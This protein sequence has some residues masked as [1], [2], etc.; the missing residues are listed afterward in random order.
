MEVDLLNLEPQHIS[1]NLKGKFIL[2][3]GEPGCGKTSLGAELPKA[4][5]LG[6]EQGTNA[7]DN[8]YVQPIQAWGDLKKSVNQL[9]RKRDVLS[10]KFEN[11]I[12][13]TV[14]S[15]WDLCVKFICASNG[16]EALGDIDWG[17]GY[18]QAKKEFSTLFRDL[19]FSGYGIFFISHADKKTV[20][21]K[22]GEEFVQIGP[23]L[24]QRPYDII[25]KMVD[26]TAFINTEEDAEGNARRLIYFR[27]NKHFF[28]KSRFRYIVPSVEYSYDNIVNAIFDAIDEQ[29]HSSGL[30]ATEEE[31]P[32]ISLDYDALMEEAK[33]LWGQVIANEARDKA[34]QILAEVFGEPK[35]FSEIQ[36][37]DVEK[38]HSV[39][40]QIRDIL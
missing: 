40:N 19:T 37:E 32:Y 20:K 18:D 24:P 2:V 23:A 39:I 16:V 9:I 25:N 3:Y 4:L 36:P 13:D 15:A 21:D 14:D 8:V 5:I 7:I 17:K 38:L 12:I 22:N 29:A 33:S 31:N 26:I 6:C 27:G 34:E 30:E 1:R 35:R 11:I 28:A 10:E